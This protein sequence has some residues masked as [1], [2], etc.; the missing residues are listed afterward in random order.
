MAAAPFAFLRILVERWRLIVAL[1]LITAV[2]TVLFTYVMR[3]IYSATVTFVPEPESGAALP[4]GL[5]ALAGQF[6]FTFGADANESPQFYADLAESRSILD[7]IMLEAVPTE[8]TDEA[9]PLLLIDLL[10]IAARDSALR[11]DLARRKLKQMIASSVNRQTNVVQLSVETPD[12]ILAAAIANRLVYYINEFNLQQRQFKARVKRI[13]VRQ[14]V[15]EGQAELRE[16]EE[17]LRRFLERNRL[18]ESSPELQFEHDRLQREVFLRQEVLTT[19]NREHEIAQIEEV[20]D[21]PVITVVDSATVPATRERPRRTRSAVVALLLGGIA[22]I[23]I[24]FAASYLQN[25]RTDA[26]NEYQA[27]GD[28][29]HGMWDDLRRILRFREREAG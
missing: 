15:D 29:W 26:S 16:S 27:L 19:L 12:P 1:P 5:A 8:G 3:P 14:R 13:F 7:A 11:V 28:A 18:F 10:D 4:T 24:A 21:T 2:I 23:V 9:E 20:N 22:A 17:K 6:G 25:L